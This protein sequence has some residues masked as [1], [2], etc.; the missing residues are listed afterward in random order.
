MGDAAVQPPAANRGRR[1][2]RFSP[3][4]LLMNPI[5]PGA[6]HQNLA[7]EK[8]EIFLSCASGLFFTGARAKPFEQSLAFNPAGTATPKL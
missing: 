4:C 5:L 6:V 8:P 7:G 3:L 2:E 1:E